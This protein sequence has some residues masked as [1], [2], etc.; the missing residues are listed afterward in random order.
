LRGAAAGLALQGGKKVYDPLIRRHHLRLVLQQAAWRL[1]RAKPIS[2][3]PDGTGA[4]PV[5]G[6]YGVIDMIGGPGWVWTRGVD[7]AEAED[8]LRK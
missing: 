6:F 5:P 1:R 4:P 7:S 3:A 2:A 8:V